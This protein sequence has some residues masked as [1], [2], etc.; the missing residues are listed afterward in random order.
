MRLSS[1]IIGLCALTALGACGD[2]FNEQALI[3]AGAGTAVSAVV[4]ANL[5]AGAVVGSA[6][7]VVYCK[8]FSNSC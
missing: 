1:A 8:E 5:A 2:T 3:G 7:N 4:G 6:A